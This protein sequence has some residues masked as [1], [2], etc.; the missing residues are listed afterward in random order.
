VSGRRG[1]RSTGPDQELTSSASKQVLERELHFACGPR[2][3]DDPEVGVSHCPVRVAP[4]HPAEGVEHAD[5]LLQVADLILG[6][7]IA[8]G[9]WELKQKDGTVYVFGHAA[10]LQAIRDRNGNQIRLTWSGANTFG[11]GHGN[12]LR[13]TSP[14]G[15]WIEFSYYPGTGLVQQAKDN[16]GRTVSYT[17]DASG[18]LWKV[19]D[20]MNHVTE[21]TYDT[22]H[23]ITKIKNRNGV[24]YVTNEY[25]TAADAP[26]PVG[27]VKKQTHAD[28]GVYEFTYTVVNG[29]STRTDVKDPHGQIRRVRF[30]GEGYT[31]NDTPCPEPRRRANCRSSS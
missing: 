12:L 2:A 10:A 14:H 9:G 19:T 4:V 5:R 25:T 1:G 22:N 16:I 20:P 13:V 21:Y 27:W 28:G 17:Y 23:R 18:R 31:L 24:E 11:S 6:G 7:V 15:R 29:K 26:T 30:N 3:T 8:N